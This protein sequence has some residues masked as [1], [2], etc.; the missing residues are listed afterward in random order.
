MGREYFS[1][2]KMAFDPAL[3]NLTIIHGLKRIYK[4]NTST[5]MHKFFP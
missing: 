2:H 4:V 5:P 1:N 3:I